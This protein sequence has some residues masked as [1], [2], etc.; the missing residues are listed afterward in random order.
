MRKS[1]S[2]RIWDE[3]LHFIHYT[4]E[5]ELVIEID[6]EM[7]LQ[8]YLSS[9]VVPKLQNVHQRK[10]YLNFRETQCNVIFTI[11][12]KRP[13]NDSNRFTFTDYFSKTKRTEMI[14][15]TGR[16]NLI[17]NKHNMV[18]VFQKP[19][20]QQ[21]FNSFHVEFKATALVQLSSV[22]SLQSNEISKFAILMKTGT[23]SNIMIRIKK[24]FIISTTEENVIC[25]FLLQVKIKY[26]TLKLIFHNWYNL[27]T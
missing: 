25:H 13:N 23:E 7:C 17:E 2:Y 16:G 21:G 1:K 3:D 12:T 14:Q 15:M 9:N 26:T 11:T 5:N 6:S 18:E 24:S 8:I 19:L 10:Y 27:V 22:S 4:E 20:F